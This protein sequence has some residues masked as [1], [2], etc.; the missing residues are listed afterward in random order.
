[1][2]IQVAIPEAHVTKPVLDAMLEGVT[3]LNEQLIRSGAVPPYDEAKHGIRWKPEPPGAEH[4]DH[5]AML[6]DRGWGDCDDI[7]PYK[8]ATDRVLGKD[9]GARAEVRKSGP[10]RWHVEE[11]HSDGSKEDPC[12]ECGMPAPGRVVGIRGAAVPRMFG[13][14][15]VVGGTYIDTPHLGLRPLG[16]R[17]GMPEAW[18]ARVDLPWHFAPGDSPTNVAMVSL[19]S[20]P[21]SDQALVGALRGAIR[22]G[23]SSRFGDQDNIDRLSAIVDAC[24]GATWE[25][26]AEEYGE[27]HATAAGQVVG[28]FFG[29]I[30]KKVKRAVTHPG[31]TLEWAIKNSPA[32]LAMKGA[33]QVLKAAKPLAAMAL[34]LAKMAAPFIPG[35]GP[36]AAMALQAASPMLQNL[37]ASGQHLPPGQAPQPQAMAWPPPQMPMMQQPMMPYGYPPPWGY[38][39][40]GQG[41][42]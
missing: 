40:P 29:N 13:R 2:R 34:P 38:G 1:M 42:G 23:Q 26:L 18:Q 16:E 37:L 39:G 28:S 24:H 36:V 6:V 11:I 8:T 12:I 32:A 27:D 21:V 10:K 14:S 20:S 19:H 3:R 15:A 35:V 22:F 33:G 25:E 7:A 17:H 31:K 41:W 9:R 30:F 5:A 4:F